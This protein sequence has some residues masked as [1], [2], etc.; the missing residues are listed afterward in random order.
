MITLYDLADTITIL[1]RAI[2]RYHREQSEEN[3]NSV[4]MA[5]AIGQSNLELVYPEETDL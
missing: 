3:W 2:D 1:I 5:A 4:L